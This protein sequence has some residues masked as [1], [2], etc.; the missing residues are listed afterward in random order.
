MRLTQLRALCLKRGNVEKVQKMELN[1]EALHAA[2][3][4]VARET[5]WKPKGEKKS[6]EKKIETLAEKLHT[7]ALH[8]V[9]FITEQGRDPNLLVRA[10]R[11]L[12]RTHAIPP[13]RDDTGWFVDML[14]VLVSWPARIRD[15][16]EEERILLRIFG[17]GS[18]Q[19]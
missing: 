16:R 4:G 7:V 14:D 8:H 2:C 15:Y 10:V 9:E 17:G 11:Y 5:L 1:T 19:S 18:A 3:L 12:A 6:T 13:M